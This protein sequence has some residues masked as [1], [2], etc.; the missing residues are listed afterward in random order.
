LDSLQRSPLAPETPSPTPANDVSIKPLFFAANVIEVRAPYLIIGA[1]QLEG[2][3]SG[4]AVKVF[5]S[6]FGG[7]ETG[8]YYG[9][10]KALDVSPRYAIIEMQ[11]PQMAAA[12]SVGEKLALKVQEIGK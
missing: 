11:E 5:R 3:Q 7:Q 9:L 2:L 1:E 8:R 10:G 4:M 6:M 12:L